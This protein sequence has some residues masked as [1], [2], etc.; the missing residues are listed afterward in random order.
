VKLLIGWICLWSSFAF[1][2]AP[3]EAYDVPK[4][5]AVEPRAFNP[6]YDL[7]VQLSYLPMDAFYKGWAP[8]L[9]YTQ[10]LSS[11]WSWEVFNAN[12]SFNTDTSL[13]K[14]LTDNFD[15]RPSN[16]SV[17][18]PVLWYA[19]TSAIYTPIYSKYLVGNESVRYG[20]V[21]YVFSAGSVNFKSGDQRPLLGA[22][23]ILRAFHSLSK[24][25][26]FDGRIYY[27]FSNDKSTD[28][29]LMLTYGFSFEMGDGKPWN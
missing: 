14:D 21:S 11:S 10:T 23:F 20:S 19:T 13:Q 22:G 6:H 5:V 17:L 3:D 4:I 28:T 25:S 2:A 12:Y 16:S 1:A 8:G 29:I 7:T 9:S 26:K 27:H 15:V 24:S 18:D